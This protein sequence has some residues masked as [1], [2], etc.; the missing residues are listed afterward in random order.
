MSTNFSIRHTNVVSS[1]LV[2]TNDN[3]VLLTRRFQTG[4]EDG[5]Y[6]LPAG[7]VEAGENF[8]DCV[9]REALEEVGVSVQQNQLTVA[10]VMHRQSD[11]L[12]NSD[13]NP[14]LA[15]QNERVDVFFV[16][17]N[18]QGKIENKEPEK[19]DHIEWFDFDSLP[20]NTIPY[21]KF[22]LDNIKK[23]IYYSE[24]GW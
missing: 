22:A 11:F 3:K 9:I 4:Y 13:H 2:L 7:H 20:A 6:S 18:W 14:Q 15:T 21:I 24:F 23:N 12:K 16:A 17:T 1:Y 19:C 10:H 5:K 8:T